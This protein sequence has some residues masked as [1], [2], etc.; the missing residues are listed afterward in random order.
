VADVADAVSSYHGIDSVTSTA[1]CQSSSSCDSRRGETCAK[2]RGATTGRCIPTWYGLCHA[3]APASLLVPEPRH[4]VTQNG[5][6]FQVNDIKALVTLAF[7]QTITRFVSQR[8][9]AS[10]ARGEIQYDE[11]GRP[12]APQCRDT[13]AGTFHLLVTNNLATGRS[14]VFDNVFDEE[15]WSR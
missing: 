2:R 8:C 6:T 9:N 5:V 14:F 13:N 4:A 11:Y 1:S 15:V 7:D 10:D 12:I 3:W